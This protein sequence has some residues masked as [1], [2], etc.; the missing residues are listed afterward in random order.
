MYDAALAIYAERGW[1]GF[2]LEAV[3][4]QAGVGQGAMYRRWSGKAE[5]LAEAVNARAPVFTLSETGDSREDLLQLARLF[6]ANYRDALGVVGLRMV[7]DAR[8]NPEL[9]EHFQ[10]MLQG[11]R[12]VEAR[13]VVA[14]AHER[15]ELR[16]PT[17]VDLCLEIIA[18][19][20]LSHVLYTPQ[21]PGAR[22]G[23]ITAADE[24]FLARLVE[25]LLA[26]AVT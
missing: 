17:T 26:P 14:H 22:N 7:L 13:A 24:R 16:E 19:T 11:G 4:R 10:R 6:V 3:G 23:R 9:A 21:K 25:S 8:T 2:S 5:L 1:Y 15:G 12:A 20:T 18:G